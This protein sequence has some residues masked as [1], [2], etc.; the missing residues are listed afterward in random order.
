MEYGRI[1]NEMCTSWAKHIINPEW[2][3]HITIY[4]LNIPCR[5]NTS[6]VTA[7]NLISGEVR[8]LMPET[9]KCLIEM[10]DWFHTCKINAFNGHDGGLRWNIILWNHINLLSLSDA[11]MRRWTWLTLLKIMFCRLS[12][13]KWLYKSTLTSYLLDHQE[14]IMWKIDRNKVF[15]EENACENDFCETAVSLSQ[16]RRVEYRANT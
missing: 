14:Q 3:S 8:G 6:T 13:A 5:A 12:C 15:I 9:I 11:N 10:I 1:P 16:G 7:T 4:H 2:N